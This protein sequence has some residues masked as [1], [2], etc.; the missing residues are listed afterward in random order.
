MS[1]LGQNLSVSSLPREW[2]LWV[3]S[4]YCQLQEAKFRFT[5][6]SGY[7]ADAICNATNSSFLVDDV[8]MNV[9]NALQ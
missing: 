8:D 3:G 5:P 9:I 2:L 7:S 1:A 4:G 6:Q